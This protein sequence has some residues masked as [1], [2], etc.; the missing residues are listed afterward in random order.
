MTYPPQ[1]GPPYGQQPYPPQQPQP[2]YGYPQQQPPQQ[3]PPQQYGYPQQYPQQQ[4]YPPQ[5]QQW[6]S[7]PPPPA[8]SRRGGG[9]GIKNILRIIGVVVAVIVLGVVWFVSRDDAREAEA[10]DCMVN[11]GS[12]VSPDLKI[13]D[14]SDSKAAYKVV[15]VFGGTLDDTKCEGKS[16]IGY[17]EQTRGTRRHAGKQFV[18]CL[19]KL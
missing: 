10:G 15:E 6:G 2:G 4:P 5:Q 17:S 12:T 18:L 13:V 16:D 9:L 19:D 3:Q 7:P 11:H 14:C 8:P 1:Q